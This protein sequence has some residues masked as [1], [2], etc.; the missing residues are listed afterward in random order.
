MFV[1]LNYHILTDNMC[2]ILSRPLARYWQTGGDKIWWE[3]TAL[4]KST[5][6]K[7]SFSHHWFTH[8]KHT[9]VGEHYWDELERSLVDKFFKC[10]GQNCGNA[11]PHS[12]RDTVNYMRQQ[13]V[14][15]SK[16]RMTR[17]MPKGSMHRFSQT[18]PEDVVS[19]QYTLGMSQI[20]IFL[21]RFYFFTHDISSNVWVALNIV[22]S[23]HSWVQNYALFHD[24]GNT[25]FL[26]LV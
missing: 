8:S 1:K 4:E 16:W 7:Y 12:T 3:L 21:R 24:F 25:L 18:C 15:T 13:G 10:V 5:C 23:I 22:S 11:C 14:L 9:W 20:S 19:D 26:Y 17:M 6:R 2:D